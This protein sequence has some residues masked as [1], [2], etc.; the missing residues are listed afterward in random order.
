MLSIT[1]RVGNMRSS[2]IYTYYGNPHYGSYWMIVTFDSSYNFICN[3]IIYSSLYVSEMLIWLRN[4]LY[5]VNTHP[6]NRLVC[7][8]I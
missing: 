4:G 7:C 3:S 2:G 5:L 1:C 8:Y 6:S